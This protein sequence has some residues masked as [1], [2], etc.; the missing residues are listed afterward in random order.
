MSPFIPEGGREAGVIG[1]WPA[2][3][4]RG[5][6]VARAARP[7]SSG[8]GLPSARGASFPGHERVDEGLGLEGLQILDALADADQ[9]DRDL[10][11]ADDPDHDPALRRAVELRQG[12]P[13]EPDRLVEHA[14]LGEA[15]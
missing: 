14:R 9:L 1:A 2:V 7:A 8:R 12:D 6:I 10:E 13:R 15:V 11:L 4:T 5:F 3:G